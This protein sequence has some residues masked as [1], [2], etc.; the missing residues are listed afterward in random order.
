[1]QF[2][3]SYVPPRAPT[4]GWTVIAVVVLS[5]LAGAAG[6]VLKSRITTLLPAT[7]EK[8]GR[9]AHG[10]SALSGMKG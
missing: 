1:M 2:V 9:A 4:G 6:V 3:Q 8:G 5:V 10:R 7:I